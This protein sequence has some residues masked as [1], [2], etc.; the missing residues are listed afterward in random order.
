MTAELLLQDK[1]AT[2]L[3]EAFYL[4][5]NPVGSGAGSWAMDKLGA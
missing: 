1:T 3:P 2:R 4:S 5:F